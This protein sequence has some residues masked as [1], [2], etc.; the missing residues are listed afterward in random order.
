MA[1]SHD[2][3]K[4]LLKGKATVMYPEEMR[5]LPEASRGRL[6]FA[7][8]LCIGCGLCWRA[9][10]A[11]AIEPVKDERGLRPIFHIDRC[12]FCYL[13]IEVCPRKAIKGDKEQ[14]P[15]AIDRSKLV[16]R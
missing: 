15:V 12:I 2:L 5:A 14:V 13:C 3:L 10:P 9:C 16:V 1:I 8:E 6:T 4:N 7:R 11:E